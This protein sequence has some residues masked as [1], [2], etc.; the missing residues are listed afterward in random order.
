MT[1]FGNIEVVDTSSPSSCKPR[2][3]CSLLDTPTFVMAVCTA[4]SMTVHSVF[5]SP[6]ISRQLWPNQADKTPD[7]TKQINPG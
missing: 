7:K 1:V 4:F 6:K 5:F 3:R 2:R